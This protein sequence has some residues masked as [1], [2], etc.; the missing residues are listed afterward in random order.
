MAA[1]T[2]A[3]AALAWLM[4]GM[5]FGIGPLDPAAFAAGGATLTASAFA[6]CYIPARRATRVDPISALHSS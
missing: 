2:V 3:A 1:G 6:A 4:R 5:L